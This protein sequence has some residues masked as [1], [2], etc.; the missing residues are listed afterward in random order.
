MAPI[1]GRA[2]DKAGTGDGDTQHL[3]VMQDMGMQ[4]TAMEIHSEWR[5][6]VY[7]DRSAKQSEAKGA[8]RMWAAGTQDFGVDLTLGK[9]IYRKSNHRHNTGLKGFCD[10][11][12]KEYKKK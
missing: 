11:E 9:G 5:S 7:R 3:K 1:S 6:T 2:G 12:K 8:L 4:L 10:L